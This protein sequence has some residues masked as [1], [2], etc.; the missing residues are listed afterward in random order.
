[1]EFGEKPRLADA[2]LADDAD[3]LAG[4]R[5]RPGAR[6]CSRSPARS[7]G[8]QKSSVRA[9]VDGRSAARA[10]ETLEQPVGRDRFGFAFQGE[11]PDR[12][13]PSIALSQS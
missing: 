2:G 5:F 1:M 13:D 9:A 4:G 7:A 6:N 12:L 3:R 8:R 10:C 11:R